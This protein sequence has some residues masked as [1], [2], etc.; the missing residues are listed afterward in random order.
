MGERCKRFNEGG[1]PVL[2][3]VCKAGLMMLLLSVIGASWAPA[4]RAEEVTFGNELISVVFHTDSGL[5][6]VTDL[7][8][9]QVY[10][11]D[12]SLGTMTVTAAQAGADGQSMT[13]S[14]TDPA[15]ARPFD[16]RVVVA[17]GAASAFR[18]RGHGRAA[19]NSLTQRRS[20][21]GPGTS[22]CF[23]WAKGSCI[24]SERLTLRNGDSPSSAP[25]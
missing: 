23:P 7:R 10:E 3:R 21:P 20:L 15:T 12:P 13:A 5:F 9:G 19:A 11:Q 1:W 8:N 24:P 4:A 17:T 16:L 2:R 25:G 6:T 18:T 22:W 14:L